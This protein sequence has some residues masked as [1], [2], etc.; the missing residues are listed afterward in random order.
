MG[1][2]RKALIVGGLLF[3][4][5]SPPATQQVAGADASLQSSTFATI[6]AAA[7]TIADFKGFCARRPQACVTGQY[8]AA[9]LEGK[10]QYTARLLYEWANPPTPSQEQIAQAPSKKALAAQMPRTAAV[11]ERR[12]PNRRGGSPLPA[13]KKP[14]GLAAGGPCGFVCC[15]ARP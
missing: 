4:L 9:T 2:I 5:P 8:L 11:W 14:A 1:L 13:R 12:F 6:S 15:R 10:A 3:A 7:E